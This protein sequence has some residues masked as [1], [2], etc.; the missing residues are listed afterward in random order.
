MT[1]TTTPY[2]ASGTGGVIKMPQYL[3]EYVTDSATMNSAS[4]S[5]LPIFPRT[6]AGMKALLERY[7]Y[8]VFMFSMVGEVIHAGLLPVAQYNFALCCGRK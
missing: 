4:K 6:G 5:G 1:V 2:D 3:R 7:F 8:A